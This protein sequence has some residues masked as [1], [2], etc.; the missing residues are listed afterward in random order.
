MTIQKP[1]APQQRADH[2]ELEQRAPVDAGAERV[3]EEVDDLHASVLVPVLVVLD[4]HRAAAALEHDQLVPVGGLERRPVERPRRAL[5]RRP[6]GRSG[7]ARGR[8][9]AR[10]PRRGSPRAACGPRRAA[11]GRRRAISVA[12]AGSTP[13]ERLVEQEHRRVLDE[14]AG[15]QGALA[16]AAGQL[17]EADAG[18]LREPDAVERRAGGL[19]IGAARRQPP[20]PVRERA[21]DRHVERA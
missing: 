18:L 10:S 8:T 14:R 2:R 9:C 20:A 13:G 4:R 7:R 16:L 21:H 17:A 5:R 19:A 1:S 11:P 6:G 3:E 12:L 15:E